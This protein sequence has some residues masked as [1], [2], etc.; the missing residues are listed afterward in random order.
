M[1]TGA[2]RRIS[3]KAFEKM[4][5]LDLSF[6]RKGSRAST[7]AINKAIRTTEQGLL[8]FLGFFT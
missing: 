4:L 8:F 3:N 1:I 6:H 7:F 5:Q 2:M